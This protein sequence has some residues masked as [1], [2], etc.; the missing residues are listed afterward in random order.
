MPAEG[1]TVQATGTGDLTLHGVTKSVQIPLEARL[2]NGVITIVG[3]L[4][5]LFADYDIDSPQSMMVLSV[6]DNG[7]LELQLQLTRAA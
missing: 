2:Q 6:E 3:T 7:V 1:A 5:I 4:P